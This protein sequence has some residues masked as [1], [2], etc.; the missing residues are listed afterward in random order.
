MFL[1]IENPKCNANTKNNFVFFSTSE[2]TTTDVACAEAAAK[3]R[4]R[5]L[6]AVQTERRCRSRALH[7]PGWNVGF[8]ACACFLF[9]LYSRDSKTV[10]ATQT[11]TTVRGDA[12]SLGR[13]TQTCCSQRDV[14]DIGKVACHMR[15]VQGLPKR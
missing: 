2:G 4:A 8:R 11:D 3:E 5:K 1:V 7:S 12:H 15:G 6:G 14:N 9:F 13:A 10:V